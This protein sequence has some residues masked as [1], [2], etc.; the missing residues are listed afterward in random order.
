MIDVQ[1]EDFLVHT[2][3]DTGLET[4]TMRAAQH[5]VK[6]SEVTVGVKSSPVSLH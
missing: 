5:L 1:L 6:S 4:Y 3:T 2:L